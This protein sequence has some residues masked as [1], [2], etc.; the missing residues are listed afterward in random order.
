MTEPA[1]AAADR[2]WPRQVEG[3]LTEL[4]ADVP[5]VMLVGPRG[6]G[7]STTAAR[8]ASTVVHLD[9]EVEAA[10]FWADPDSALAALA[11]PVLL[12][13][14]QDVPAV[15]GAVK[16]AVDAGTPPGSF[17]LAG[18]VRAETHPATW[19]GTGRVIR[20]RMYP[21]T[22]A[23]QLHRSP[24]PLVDRLLAGAPLAPA[25]DP[26]DLRGYVESAIAG[27]FPEATLRVPP[28]SRRLW[29]QSYVEQILT[30]DV[31]PNDNGRG[32]DSERLGRFLLAYAVNSAGAA[33]DATIFTAAGINR[34]TAVAYEALLTDLMVVDALPA[35]TT[36][37]LKR[38]TRSPKRHLVDT[39]LWAAIMGVDALAVLRDGDLL[40]RSL[41]SFV[42]AQLRAEAVVAA[43]PHKLFHLRTEQGRHEVDVVA[44]VGANRIVGV[45]VKASGAP[46]A[47]AAR[48]LVW[49]RD[50]L[51]E[52]FAA[53]VVLHTGTAVYPLAPRITAAPICT[54]WA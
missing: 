11:T 8:L 34:A 41:E 48:H 37:R 10:G 23:E 14:W 28:R 16:R 35:W 5:A 27:G 32:R 50:Q 30:Q 38:L 47:D 40:G 54:L 4:M 45:E 51:G 7:K 13:E 29:L 33:A 1:G 44:E 18:S 24:P 42:T 19:P 26:P 3:L 15:L 6:V 25:A 20:L 53:G 46:T 21:L 43:N 12:D 17:L 2:Y 39:G 49:L 9:R 52:R 31:S 36:N 22:V